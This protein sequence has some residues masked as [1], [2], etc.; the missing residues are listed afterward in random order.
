M[1]GMPGLDAELYTAKK[2]ISQLGR[3]VPERAISHQFKAAFS[4]LANT[5]PA[6]FA[7]ELLPHECHLT[8]SRLHTCLIECQH[9]NQAQ[10]FEPNCN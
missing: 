6:Q 5:F 8:A 10:L 2:V 3:P 9:V 4:K 1:V 7:I